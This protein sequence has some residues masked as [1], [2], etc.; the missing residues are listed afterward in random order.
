MNSG[1]PY[2]ALLIV[3]FGGPERREDVVPFLENVTRGRNVP[4]ERLLEVAKHYDRFA[5]RS[6][7]NQQV[8]DLIE[9]LSLELKQ[10]GIEL[11][12]FWGNR[13]WHPMLSDTVREMANA[14]VKRAL[15]LALAAYSSYSSCR[16]YLEDIAKAR[17]EVGP[18]APVIDKIRVFF[19]HPAFISA[20]AARVAAALEEVPTASRDAVRLVFTAHSLPSGMARACD[21][22]QQLRESARLI[23]ESLQ[24]P[25][26]RWDLVFQSRSGPPAVPWLEPDILSHLKSLSEA[27]IADVVVAPIGFLSDHLEVIYDLDCEA[28]ELCAE[29]GIRMVRAGT[30]GTHPD[31]VQ[32]LRQLIEE[33]L[34]EDHPRLAVGTL[35]PRPDAC[36]EDCCPPPARPPGRR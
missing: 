34:N 3:G 22:V 20:N 10:G 4:P 27:G 8:R 31:F 35:L 19:N 7:I 5:G 17:A 13:N 15:G 32:M 12:I 24:V 9:S 11:P 29:L 28:R 25:L 30:V 2:D 18:D 6:P 36:P 26:D 14:G 1:N 23:S 16:Q 21:Y 33:R